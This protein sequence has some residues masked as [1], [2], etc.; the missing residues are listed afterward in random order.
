MEREVYFQKEK[1]KSLDERN[2]NPPCIIDRPNPVP[3]PKKLK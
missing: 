1:N 3:A 2:P